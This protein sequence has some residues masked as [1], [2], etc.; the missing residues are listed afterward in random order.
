MS[1]VELHDHGQVIF[2]CPGCGFG[3]MIRVGDGEGPRWSW[4]G[5]M[6]AP[7]FSP[8]VLLRGVEQLTEEEVQIVEAGGKVTPRPLVCH[9]FVTEGKIRFL[10]DS[11]HKLAGQTVDL[12]EVE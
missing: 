2:D 6:D 8:S 11:T 3:H 5:S 1:K 7:T 10:E 4:N 9:S 12:P